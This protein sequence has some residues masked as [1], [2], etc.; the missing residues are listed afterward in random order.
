MY[1]SKAENKN[2]F[3]ERLKESLLM[4]DLSDQ[5][6]IQQCIRDFVTIALYKFTFTI[7]ITITTSVHTFNQLGVCVSSPDNMTCRNADQ[8]LLI[9]SVSVRVTIASTQF[10]YHGGMVR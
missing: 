2:V 6:S 1:T 3:S 9:L 4:A 10:A 8:L 7:T 5:A